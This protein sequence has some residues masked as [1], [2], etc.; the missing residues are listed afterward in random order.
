M[1]SQAHDYGDES[2]ENGDA[3]EAYEL[4]DQKIVDE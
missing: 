1:T 4:L 3:H 2:S